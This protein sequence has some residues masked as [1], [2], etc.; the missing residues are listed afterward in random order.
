MKKEMKSKL[1]LGLLLFSVVPKV[2]A[3]V[4]TVTIDSTTLEKGETKTLTINLPENIAS[5]DGTITS[6]DPACIEVVSVASSNGSGNYFMDISLNG[7]PLSNAGTVT[8][9]G[10]KKCEAVLN[11]SNVNLV[12]T[13]EVEESSLYFTS[14]K[15]TINGPE[16][17]VP[18]STP[19]N[20]QSESNN[21]STS[22]NTTKSTQSAESVSANKTNQIVNNQSS[23]KTTTNN[24]QPSRKEVTTNPTQISQVDTNSND[25]TDM[26][27]TTN[28]GNSLSSLVVSGY[29]IDFKQDTTTYTIKV[30]KNVDKLDV[31][32]LALDE[33][34]KVTIEGN[35]S[36]VDGENT[37][38]VIVE[39]VDGTTKTYTII[40]I[41]DD[42]LAENDETSKKSNN[43]YLK[44]III[45]NGELILNNKK[46]DQFDKKV[47]TYYYKKGENF[48]Y[49]YEVDDSNAKVKVLE[50]ADTINIVVEAENGDIRVYTL[51]P[52]KVNIIKN[53][54]L[55]ILGVI[56]GYLLRVLYFQIKRKKRRKKKLKELEEN[57]LKENN[58]SIEK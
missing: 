49:K 1:L 42:L 56:I 17:V 37:V 21:E 18:V 46:V 38:N 11:I 5:V 51:I 47:A 9:K 54:V 50:S 15:I 16:E 19:Q 55:L 48:S 27:N 45:N 28:E 23:N 57:K 2:S 22:T 43:N 58:E 12:T 14:G 13:S 35:D 31:E 29:D 40:A 53:F 7:K 4:G 32:A 10:L 41:R 30:D 24:I 25:G 36:L 39:S 6:S 3:N 52:Y 44:N 8:I 34:A 20:T 26:S 33:N